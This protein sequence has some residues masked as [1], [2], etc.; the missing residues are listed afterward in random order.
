MGSSPLTW[1]EKSQRISQTAKNLDPEGSC[2][3]RDMFEA[4]EVTPEFSV[5][6]EA[7]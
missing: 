2:R 5:E 3:F 6:I 1:I 4:A 7:G